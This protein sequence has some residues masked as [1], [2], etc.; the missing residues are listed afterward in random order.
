[1]KTYP[2]LIE[3]GCEEL[4]FSSLQKTAKTIEENIRQALEQDS[5]SFSSIRSLYTP[6]RIAVLIEDLIGMQ[7]DKEITRK[8]PML[9]KAFQDGKAMPAALGFA[10]SCG[11][12]EVND[13]I[14]K[15]ENRLIHHSW[16][17][18]QSTQEWLIN[19]LPKLLTS[20]PG[21]QTMRWGDGDEC[22]PR[23]VH[24][25]TVVFGQE[26]IPVEAL[27]S[28]ASDRSY[29]HRFH[30]PQDI[31][32]NP[33]NYLDKLQEN[34]VL[35]DQQVRQKH[36]QD[37]IQHC[38]PKSLKVVKD[39]GLLDEVTTLVEWPQVFLGRLEEKFLSLP[40]AMLIAVMK[41]HQKSFAM[42]N[43]KGEIQPYFL[44]VNNIET[45]NIKQVTKDYESV[46]HAR[47]EDAYFFYQ[48]DLKKP[49]AE[50]A[51]GLKTVVFQEKLGSLVD[52]VD[53]VGKLAAGLYGMVKQDE[54]PDF[55]K[56]YR[57]SKADLMTGS[58][59]E[60][61]ELESIIGEHLALDQGL[62]KSTATIIRT[63]SCPKFAN[64][65]LP[66]SLIAQCLSMAE[67]IDAIVGFIGIEQTPTADKDPFGIRRA[68]I[69]CLRLSIEGGLKIDLR[70]AI[71]LSLDTYSQ[72][73]FSNKDVE[74]QSLNFIFE[75]LQSWCRQHDVPIAVYHA[76]QAKRLNNLFDAYARMQA[77]ITFM[78]FPEAETLIAAHKRVSQ[79]LKKTEWTSID[80]SE[81]HFVEQAEKD[82]CT[83]LKRV[84]EQLV[85]MLER[86]EYSKVM[87]YLANYK[88]LIDAFFDQVMVIS[89][90][91][92]LRENRLG[93]LGKLEQQMSSVVCINLL[94]Q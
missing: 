86:K 87:Q 70:S 41:S 82:L 54:T 40:S 27:K 45:E 22:F 47:L 46:M 67:K 11:V 34:Y 65:L 15:S 92:A 24:W 23:P 51:K 58:V 3:I 81:K 59:F 43:D 94:Q 89:E 55:D 88:P 53:R 49:L 14:D 78:E 16:V 91:K 20:L 42:V 66:D 25:L 74:D 90:D 83:E 77:A 69:G 48:Q 4:P 57:L 56:L 68:A 8:G 63:A 13:L 62:D 37:G 85:S 76:V 9:Q 79:I 32:V 12:A 61:P 21:I 17:K 39:N 71:R 52:R 30:S 10:R 6:R 2:L 35:V 29:G 18:G 28:K 36:I 44:G 1:M 73:T 33:A 80:F 19:K 31:Q 84:D 50:H 75:R 72:V 93:L 7:P 26:I 64:D 38:L 5:L 60:F